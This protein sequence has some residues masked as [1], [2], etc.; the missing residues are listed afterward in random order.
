MIKQ[1]NRRGILSLVCGLVILV[2]SPSIAFAQS[3][4]FGPVKFLPPKGFTRN[5]TK[6][7]LIFRQVDRRRQRFCL[8]TLY[9]TKVS[10]ASPKKGFEMEWAEKVVGPWGAL[11]KPETETELLNRLIFVSA[12]A[13]VYIDGNKATAYLNVFSAHGKSASL[14]GI[15]NDNSCSNVLQSFIDSLEID[16]KGN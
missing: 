3:D 4:K 13:E 16:P 1:M 8:I 9:T 6:D 7:A 14:L 15:Y 12:G 2:C 5:Q 11:D 10:E